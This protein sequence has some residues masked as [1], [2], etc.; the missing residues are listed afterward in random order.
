MINNFPCDKCGLCCKRVGIAAD[1]AFLDRGDG[2]CK[3]Y[4]DKTKLC[5]IYAERP[6]VCRVNDYYMRFLVEKMTWADYVGLN[7]EMCRLIK[8]EE[9]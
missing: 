2:V 3:H 6:L 9:V 8:L 1:T 5:L 7:V 4:C